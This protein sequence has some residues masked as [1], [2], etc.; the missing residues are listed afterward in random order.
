VAAVG[1]GG[2]VAA[3]GPHGNWAAEGAGGQTYAGYH[4][5]GDWDSYYGSGWGGVAAG[6]A[7]GA[8]VGAAATLASLPDYTD[9]VVVNNQTY[10]MV[11]GTYYQPCYQGVDVNYCSVPSPY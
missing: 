2:S 9:P 1:P 4:G 7:V 8:A 3:E 5:G 10:Y 11:G 6:A